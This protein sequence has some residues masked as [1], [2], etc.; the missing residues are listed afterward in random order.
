MFAIDDAYLVFLSWRGFDPVFDSHFFDL[1]FPFGC[2]PYLVPL[3]RH[4]A[5]RRSG[6]PHGRPGRADD[7]DKDDREVEVAVEGIAARVVPIPVPD[8]RYSSLL[9]VKGG[10][11]W[12]RSPLPAG[13]A[14]AP[15]RTTTPSPSSSATTCATTREEITTGIDWVEVSG[16]GK[17]LVIGRDGEPRVLASDGSDDGGDA[18]AVDLSRLRGPPIR[19]PSGARPTPRLAGWSATTS[20][21]VT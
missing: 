21:P 15:T 5:R 14:R 2:R 10:L 7:D 3:G 18:V 13:S 9:P 8:G 20:G 19:R 11:V 1:S 4:A 17:R 6:R 12:L 16:D